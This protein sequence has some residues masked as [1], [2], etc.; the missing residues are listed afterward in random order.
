MS[1]DFSYPQRILVV[2]D[3]EI[4]RFITDK[5]LRRAHF[6]GQTLFRKTGKEALD[7]LLCTKPEEQPDLVFLDLNMPQMGGLAFL[8]ALEECWAGEKIAFQIYVLSSSTLASDQFA[9][10]RFNF[11]RGYLVKPLS[12]ATAAGILSSQTG[13]KL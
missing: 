2:D 5:I 12:V 9:A 1:K 3:S 10:I 13:F 7:F 8:K 4:D 11:V 6:S